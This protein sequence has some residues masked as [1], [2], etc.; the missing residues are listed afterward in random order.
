MRVSA[1]CMC[2]VCV[3][4]CAESRPMLVCCVN[5]CLIHLNQ[6]QFSHFL[7]QST[8]SVAAGDRNHLRWSE[9]SEN[10]G[11]VHLFLPHLFHPLWVSFIGPNTSQHTPPFLFDLD[12][13]LPTQ[14]FHFLTYWGTLFNSFIHL[15]LQ[16]GTDVTVNKNGR[17]LPAPLLPPSLCV[18]SGSREFNRGRM[19]WLLNGFPGSHGLEN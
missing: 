13:I 3:C 18:Q 15:C 6:V 12:F 16:A 9:M 8:L 10:N 2:T 17:A 14:T 4:V 11:E 5:V 19:L 7:S 1:A